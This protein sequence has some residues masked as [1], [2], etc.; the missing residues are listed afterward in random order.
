[1]YT[2]IMFE[3]LCRNIAAMLAMHYWQKVF[4][5]DLSLMICL[6]HRKLI[7]GYPSK[8]STETRL[9]TNR[10]DWGAA[11]LLRPVQILGRIWH[12]NSEFEPQNSWGPCMLCCFVFLSI[13]NLS[14]TSQIIP[15]P[16][17]HFDWLSVE[18]IAY[19]SSSYKFTLHCW[20]LGTDALC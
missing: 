8:L 4:D 7:T 12:E 9:K 14:A 19:L 3:Y 13:P 1:M 18:L 15:C 16:S 11:L 20:N 10:R 2:V 6:K 17:S 5:D